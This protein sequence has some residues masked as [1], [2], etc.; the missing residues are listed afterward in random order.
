VVGL[1]NPGDQYSETRHNVG[2]MAVEE[3][4]RRHGISLKRTVGRSMSGQSRVGEDLLV[5]AIPGVFMNLSGESVSPLVK[6]HSIEDLG[7]LVVVHDELDIEPGRIQ[8]KLGGGLAGHNGLKSIKA[9]L[10]SDE[11]ARVRIGIGRPPGQQ[12]TSDYV[13]RRPGSDDRASL[14]QAIDRA[15]DAVEEILNSGMAN[16]MNLYNRQ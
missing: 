9:H 3:L 2:Q 10:K 8:L 1:G 13:L 14:A 6:R 4:A 16:A 11:F 12:P 15:A 7:S 5:L